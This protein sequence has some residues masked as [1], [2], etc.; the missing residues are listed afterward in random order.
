MSEVPLYAEGA[1]D[2]WTTERLG[3]PGARS[4]K[5]EDSSRF[6]SKEVVGFDFVT[7]TWER[8]G[9]GF[10]VSGFLLSKLDK[11]PNRPVVVCIRLWLA[12]IREWLAGVYVYTLEAG[13]LLGAPTSGRRRLR[14]STWLPPPANEAKEGFGF[15]KKT[16]KKT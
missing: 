13:A 16:P 9:R 11:D 14:D 3:T 5:T 2:T 8:T 4:S 10:Q 12:Y 1:C 7:A 6:W 15:M